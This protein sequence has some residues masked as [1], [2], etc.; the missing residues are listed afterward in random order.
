MKLSN[1]N[2]RCFKQT[3]ALAKILKDVSRIGNQS[4]GVSAYDVSQALLGHSPMTRKLSIEDDGARRNV[5]V[6]LIGDASARPMAL[7][8]LRS[9][10]GRI[11]EMR[12]GASV[13]RLYKI[14]RRSRIRLEITASRS[15]S[16]YVVFS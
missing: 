5:V 16:Y 6:R 3:K 8:E 7:R 2:K 4:R 9:E 13:V 1:R 10:N 14:L 12:D 15:T 11:D